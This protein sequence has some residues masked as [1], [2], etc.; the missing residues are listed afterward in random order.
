MGWTSYTP[1][2]YNRGKIDRKAE[3]DAYFLE[4]L[5]RGHYRVEKS[6]MVGTTYYAAVTP[7]RCYDAQTK[8]YVDIPDA[9]QTTHAFVFLTSVH[10]GE[11]FYKDMHETMF[12]GQINCPVGILNL[13]SPTDDPNAHAWREACR[14]E[15]GKKL[16]DAKNP[17]SLS[18]LPLGTV[19]EFT[20][21]ATGETV[22]YTKTAP[23]AQFK[24][25]FWYNA[26]RHNYIP[27]TRI[28]QNYTIIKRG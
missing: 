20:I 18:N 28:P 10:N 3:C 15:H 26:A 8:A 13:L 24:T 16:D 23:M 4:G 7:L 21:P 17:D 12:P 6:A 22:Q 2:H 11:F 1:T 25:P 19:I 14:R 27:K 5:N 9:E